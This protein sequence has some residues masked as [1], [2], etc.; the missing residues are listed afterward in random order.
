MHHTYLTGL[1]GYKNWTIFPAFAFGT[2]MQLLSLSHNDQSFFPNLCIFLAHINIVLGQAAINH[3][4]CTKCE[5]ATPIFKQLS[6]CH[7]SCGAATQVNLPKVPHRFTNLPKNQWTTKIT[8]H[9]QTITTQPLNKRRGPTTLVSKLP[10]TAKTFPI[11]LT[12]IPM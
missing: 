11:H 2:T 8:A 12:N 10:L 3:P 4:N 1:K 7:K 5:M 9:L 6:H